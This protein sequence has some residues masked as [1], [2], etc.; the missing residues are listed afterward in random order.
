M[1][2]VKLEA[3]DSRFKTVRFN[4]TG[5]SLILGQ[6]KTPAVETK[7]KTRTYNGVGK[8]LLLE[9][10]HFCLGSNANDAFKKHL[11]DWSFSLTIELDGRERIITRSAGKPSDISLD[12]DKIALTKLNE[13]LLFDC[14]QPTAGIKGLTFQSLLSPF[15]RSGRGAY[16]RFD[17]A[18]DGDSKAE[19]WPMV[20]NAFL[21]GLDLQLAQSKYQLRSRQTQLKKT[22]KQLESDPLF[23]DL[24]A[25]DKAGI[26]LRQLKED[27]A[28]LEE[29]L[30][31]FAVAEDHAE[32][33]RE[34]N[35]IKRDLEAARRE[36]VKTREAIAQVDRSLETKGDLDPT[37][38]ERV[39]A[40]AKIA[41]PQAIRKDISEVMAFQRDLTQ[42]RVYRLTQDRQALE[43]DRT[44]LEQRVRELGS[45]LDEKLRYLGTHVALDEYLAVNEQLNG[46]R[47]RIAKL[48]ASKEQ[49]EKVAR[50]LKTIDLKLAEQA[51][52]TDDYLARSSPLIEEANTIFRGFTRPLY[53][54]LATGLAVTNDN[55]E[56]TLRYKIEAHIP[57]DA[58]EGINEAKIFCYDLMMLVLRRGHAMQF[59]AHDSS[60]F[61]PVDH[62]QRLTMFQIA[63]QLAR[64]KGF[65][66][67]ATLNEHDVTS[68]TP[69]D[70]ELRAE[71]ERL[72]AEP[73]VILRLTDQSPRDRLLGID[74]DMNYWVKSETRPVHEGND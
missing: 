56:N 58:A 43:H 71:F 70:P 19:Y 1:R 2:L 31:N 10:L 69:N 50:E 15:I 29:D 49:R 46:L 65:Q 35:G 72:F 9:L 18:N 34:A 52:K 61:S 42:K 44:L 48:Q 68:M 55:G 4:R 16:E 27:E 57:R 11:P 21:L 3:N 12:G 26:E 45:R 51:I 28:R 37:I 40:E 74:V 39:Y 24:L 41:L 47:Q 17:R 6:K 30:R 14:F 73:H 64:E 23:A 22:M 5:L 33:E 13:A 32:I 8:S 53:D 62:R 63:D 54:N 60:L 59:L 20:R 67:I 36:L 7:H 25:D 38:V 66:Y